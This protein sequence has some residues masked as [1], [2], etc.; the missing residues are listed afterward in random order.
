M[1]FRAWRAFSRQAARSFISRCRMPVAMR[2]G[3]PE[4]WAVLNRVTEFLYV[5]KC[6]TRRG[7]AGWR[8]KTFD[9]WSS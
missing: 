3:G 4:Q 2:A 9:A 8:C 1:T 6:A 5:F 7:F